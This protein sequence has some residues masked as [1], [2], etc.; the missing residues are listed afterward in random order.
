MKD[1]DWYAVHTVCS[2]RI[3]MH[4]LKPDEKRM[5][6]RRLLDKMRRKSSTNDV[7]M[8]AEYVAGLLGTTARSIERYIAE[9]PSADKR[10]C[11]VC[12]EDM[13][14]I[15]SEVEPHPTRLFEECPM[16]YSLTRRG[17]AAIRPDLYQW[18]DQVV[19]A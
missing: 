3:A 2:E 5:V 15:G 7:A 4:H 13:W 17:L 12:R 8:T 10:I 1:I 6:V 14:V 11:P 9:L 19:S 16:S 18:A